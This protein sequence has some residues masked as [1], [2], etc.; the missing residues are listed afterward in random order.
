MDDG[1]IAC[2][3]NPAH[4]SSGEAVHLRDLEALAASPKWSVRDPLAPSDETRERPSILRR[5]GAACVNP[6]W[7]P[8]GRLNA[9]LADRGE[10]CEL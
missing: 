7:N 1:R 9:E 4:V 10:S 2:G 8:D 3:V 6:F 5:F